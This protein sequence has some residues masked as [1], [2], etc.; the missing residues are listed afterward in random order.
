MNSLLQRTCLLC[1]LIACCGGC[2]VLEQPGGSLL[3]YYPTWRK[4]LVNLYLV[5]REPA[6]AW[7]I[8]CCVWFCLI[9]FLICFVLV[10]FE[11][12]RTAWWMADY[13]AP[14]P[15]RHYS[16]SNSRS[17]TCLNRGKFQLIKWK[18]KQKVRIETAKRSVN[19]KGKV[20]YQGTSA[21]KATE[22]LVL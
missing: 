21:L 22:Y 20:C 14:T 1:L 12:F 9:H 10:K 5:G 6:V 2:F 8:F 19:E 13:S 18:Q 7:M 3:E 4:V 16:W 11:V 17:I 15:K